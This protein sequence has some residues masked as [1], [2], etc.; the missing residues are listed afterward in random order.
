M[1]PWSFDVKG[2]YDEVIFASEALKDNPLH[3]PYQRP[4]WIYVPPG[5]ENEPTRRYPAI[6]MI[7][8]F[9]GPTGYVAQ[10]CAIPQELS[11]VGR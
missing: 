7:S 5:Y 3:D 10:P 4:L 2:R 9:D 6:Y 1:K 8:G 11:R